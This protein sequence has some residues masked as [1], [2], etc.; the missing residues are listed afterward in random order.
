[1]KGARDKL[2][3]RRPPVMTA[4]EQFRDAIRNFG[5]TPPDMIEPGHFHRFPGGGKNNGNKAGWCKLFKNGAGGI[6]GDYLSGL[7]ERL[8]AT[9]ERRLTATE[10]EAFRQHVECARTEAAA[11]SADEQVDAAQRAKAE[12]LAAKP[13]PDS[14]PPL[15]AKGI[16]SHGL[17]VADDGRLIVPLRADG[18]LCSLQFTGGALKERMADAGASATFCCGSSE[19]RP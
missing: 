19:R 14:Q 9:R 6:F 7:S 1:M 10:N 12:W 11:N 4:T 2:A 17:R 16:K 18:K 3:W 8:Q 13:A 5:L 15:L